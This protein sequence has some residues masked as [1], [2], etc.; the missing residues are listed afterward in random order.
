MQAHPNVDKA[1]KLNNI[2]LFKLKKPVE[3]LF[4]TCGKRKFV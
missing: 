2:R 4:V 1:R 3:N